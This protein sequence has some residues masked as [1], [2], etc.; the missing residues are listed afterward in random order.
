[1]RPYT[2]PVPDR[3]EF[4]RASQRTKKECQRFLGWLERRTAA[5][6]ELGGLLGRVPRDAGGLRSLPAVRDVIEREAGRERL[7]GGWLRGLVQDRIR[8]VFAGIDTAAAKGTD[9]DTVLSRTAKRAVLRG[10]LAIGRIVAD[11]LQDAARAALQARGS[12]LDAAACGKHRE[13]S[14]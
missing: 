4:R 6:P 8:R 9:A 2:L 13:A 11:A 5:A 1:M 10:D 12:P 14:R 7:E 3:D